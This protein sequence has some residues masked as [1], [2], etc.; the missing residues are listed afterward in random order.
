MS[1]A[2]H[3]HLETHVHLRPAA[4][5]PRF[6]LLTIAVGWRLAGAAGL[7]AAIWAGVFWA[8]HA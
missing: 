3:S 4:A 8:L 1:D 7:G 6:S 2:T 5:A